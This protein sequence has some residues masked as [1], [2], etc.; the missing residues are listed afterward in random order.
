MV[1]MKRESHKTL[2]SIMAICLN[3]LELST[4][5]WT[6]VKCMI[7]I[8]CFKIKHLKYIPI[9]VF[10]REHS[11]MLKEIL[12]FHQRLFQPETLFHLIQYYLVYANVRLCLVKHKSNRI[13]P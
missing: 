10:R 9:F 1:K 3:F 11:A 12:Q 13:V 6:N 8:E 7:G 2:L 4:L 5:Q